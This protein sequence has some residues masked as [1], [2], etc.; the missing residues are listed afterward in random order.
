[1]EAAKHRRGKYNMDTITNIGPSE[2]KTKAAL[3]H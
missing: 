2:N 1:M 3:Q